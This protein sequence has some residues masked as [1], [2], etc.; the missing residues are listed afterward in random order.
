[1][2][3]VKGAYQLNWRSGMLGILKVQGIC[4]K[5]RFSVQS[6]RFFSSHNHYPN[7]GK[8]FRGY[9]DKAGAL[10]DKI[11][12]Y[13]LA[14]HVSNQYYPLPCLCLEFYV[15]RRFRTVLLH[16]FNVAAHFLPR[17]WFWAYFTRNLFQNSWLGVIIALSRNISRP[18]GWEALL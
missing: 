16:L 17:L 5:T 11:I 4:F 6:H 1:M 10:A 7:I 13:I 12:K 3:F 18:I 15:Y 9:A 2:S 8:F 14:K